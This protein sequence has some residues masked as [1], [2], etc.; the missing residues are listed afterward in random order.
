MWRMQCKNAGSTWL[1]YWN[2]DCTLGS[3]SFSVSL[4]MW[5]MSR[6][7]PLGIVVVVVRLLP[8][9]WDDFILLVCS[10]M[11]VHNIIIVHFIK[12]SYCDLNREGVDRVNQLYPFLP[13]SFLFCSRVFVWEHVQCTCKWSGGGCWRWWISFA[14]LAW[15]KKDFLPLSYQPVSS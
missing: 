4:S 2:M 5:A 10:L 12:L 1:K 8:F 7:W 14:F 15:L 13:L 11:F 3:K 6:A 9:W